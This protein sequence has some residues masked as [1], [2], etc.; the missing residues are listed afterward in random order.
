MLVLPPP[1]GGQPYEVGDALDGDELGLERGEAHHHV[2]RGALQH[3]RVEQHEPE[4][5]GYLIY[6][7]EWCV[8]SRRARA[9]LRQLRIG[10][11]FVNVDEHGG[12]RAAVQALGAAEGYE[13][14]KGIPVRRP[15]PNG[16]SAECQQE[17]TQPDDSL[18]GNLQHAT[19][20]MP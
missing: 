8:F 9:L 19:K 14:L 3:A 2:H 13:L 12:S 20:G 17:F 5:R 4:L 6:G 7:A 10:A 1:L 15:S 18:L 16:C 11:A